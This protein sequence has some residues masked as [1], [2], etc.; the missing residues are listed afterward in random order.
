MIHFIIISSILICLFFSVLVYYSKIH[1]WVKSIIMPIT[2]AFFVFTI[3]Y[4]YSIIGTPIE[5]FPPD[6]FIY[7]HHEAVEGGD[8]II[9]W[10]RDPED[11]Q[12][13]LY[14]FEYSSENMKELGEAQERAEGLGQDV[15]MTTLEGTVR[16]YRDRVSETDRIEDNRIKSESEGT[17]DDL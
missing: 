16:I 4:F 17:N 5:I 15:Y 1:N 3:Q 11:N 7:V 13:R 9:L 14:K 10:A 12:H 6:E 8:Y 2:I